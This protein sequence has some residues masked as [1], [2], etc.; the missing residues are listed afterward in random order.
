MKFNK[1]VLSIFVLT[2]MNYVE[3]I[4]FSVQTSSQLIEALAQVNAG[5]TISLADGTYIGK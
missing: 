2:L 1:I 4:T 3:A 5:D